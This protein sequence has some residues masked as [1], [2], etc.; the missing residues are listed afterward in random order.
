MKRN[1]DGTYSGL[2]ID[3]PGIK[4]GD[5]LL[6]ATEYG[7]VLLEVTKSRWLGDPNDMY[8]VS[9]TIVERR[10]TEKALEQGEP[11]W[12]YTLLKETK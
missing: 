3:T 9:A 5:T 11:P 10:V 12:E 4:E 8:E 6:W 2:C 1:D 7:E